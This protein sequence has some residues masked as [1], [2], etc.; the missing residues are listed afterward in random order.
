MRCHQSH[1]SG[2]VVESV[3]PAAIEAFAAVVTYQRVELVLTG[4]GAVIPQMGPGRPR[5][6][7]LD[8]SSAA[9]ALARRNIR[10]LLSRSGDAG[11]V[12][13]ALGAAL[14]A[15]PREA[16]EALED[17]GLEVNLRYALFASPDAAIRMDGRSLVITDGEQAEIRIAQ[18]HLR[19]EGR[20]FFGRSALSRLGRLDVDEIRF[21]PSAVR[22]IWMQLEPGGVMPPDTAHEHLQKGGWQAVRRPD[23]IKAHCV[24]CGRCFI[25]CPEN[26]VIHA[27]YDKRAKDTTGILGIDSD[28]C[29]AC[30]LCAAVCPT[31]SDGY[32]A[33]VMVKADAECSPLSH[34]VG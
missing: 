8:G 34:C 28:R 3:A 31:N 30:G 2:S 13:Q 9:I 6:R 12:A 24:A 21:A 18:R 5:Q 32:K 20:A 11:E 17:V 15:P 26:A 33:I 7:L 23:F 16:E 19:G 10:S 25:H 14:S 27:A 29:T 22:P 1:V 4:Q